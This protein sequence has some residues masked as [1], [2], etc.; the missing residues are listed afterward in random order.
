MNSK[1]TSRVQPCKTPAKTIQKDPLTQTSFVKSSLKLPKTPTC[2]THILLELW[3]KPDI[4]KKL[5]SPLNSPPVHPN[6]SP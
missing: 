2:F 5:F 3:N 6:P 1:V 4:Q